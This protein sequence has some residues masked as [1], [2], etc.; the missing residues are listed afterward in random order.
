MSFLKISNA[1]VAFGKKTL[2]WK[3]YT[4]NKTLSTIKQVKLVDP[5][6]FVIVELNANSE[7]FVVHVAIRKQEEMAMDLDRKAKIDA[8]SRAHVGALIFDEAPTKVSA[9]YSDYNNVFSAENAVEL[10]ENIGI[11]EH[12]IKLKEGKQPLFGPI[13]SLGPIELETLKTYI[14]TNLA[15]GFI[16]P[17]RSSVGALILFDQ[18]QMEAS[19]FVWIIGIS[20]ILLSK[21]NIYCLWLV[22]Y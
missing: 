6:K 8:Q 14:K 11:N 15:N 1:D 2:T 4:T 7:T 20:I 18:S 21:T 5:Q 19:V 17:L 16:Q 12:A 22:N 13:Y 10:T 9:E 3:L